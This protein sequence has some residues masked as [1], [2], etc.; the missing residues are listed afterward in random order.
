M[1]VKKNGWTNQATK[2]NH[3]FTNAY[4]TKTFARPRILGQMILWVRCSK[5]HNTRCGTDTMLYLIRNGSQSTYYEDM[6][7]KISKILFLWNVKNKLNLYTVGG[8]NNLSSSNTVRK[9]FV[10]I[11]HCVTLLS[12]KNRKQF[13]INI[14]WNILNCCNLEGT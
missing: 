1:K 10:L 14:K 9:L 4:Q 5:T 7:R 11:S 3:L 13:T 2:P 8:F 12:F 6:I